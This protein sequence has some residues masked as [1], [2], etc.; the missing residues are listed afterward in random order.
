MT[1]TTNRLSKKKIIAGLCFWLL[2]AL[3]L[4]LFL[5]KYYAYHFFFIE[6]SQMFL[7]TT[8]FWND[9]VSNI[10]GFNLWLTEFLVQFFIYPYSGAAIEALLL[11]LVGSGTSC[12]I[13]RLDKNRLLFPLSLLPLISLMFMQFDFN[14]SLEGTLAF[15]FML[16]ALNGYVRI[17]RIVVRIFSGIIFSIALFLLFG[18]IALLFAICGLV[19]EIA[20]KQKRWFL[21][22]IPLLLVLMMGICS[23]FF[24][25]VDEFRW[26]FLP[27]AYYIDS[28]I[29]KNVIYYSWMA[30][31]GVII[32]SAVTGQRIKDALPM[33][34]RIVIYSLQ[35]IFV[36]LV[37]YYG[38]KEYNEGK[39]LMLKELDYYARTEQWDKTIKRCRGK[40]SNYLYKCHLNMALANQGRLADE[41]FGYD[42]AGVEGLLVKWNKT[43]NISCMLSDIYYTMGVLAPAQEMA[44]EGFVCAK[45]NSNPRMLKRLIETNLIY[46]EYAVAEKYISLLERTFAYKEWAS[47][48]RRFLYNDKT[49]L[50]DENLGA[51]RIALPDTGKLALTDGLNDELEMV[52]KENPDFKNSIEYLGA[53]YLLSKDLQSFQALIDKYY[54]TKALP[55]LPR[56]FQEAL[57]VMSEKETEMWERYNI[58][59]SIIKRFSTYKQQV[60]GNKQNPGIAN[61]LYSSFGDTYWFYFMFK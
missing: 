6:Q 22:T 18:S 17:R 39:S 58:S 45:G 34:K 33:K 53:I 35:F 44:F 48:Q 7:W 50:E 51:R 56:S 41:M 24:A 8:S 42:Q 43:E 31:V 4:F 59:E 9:T 21:G 32:L 37:F 29:P 16:A 27:D 55:T 26:A 2:V 13:G 19:Y 40:L 30:L 46:G 57:I 10:G 61:I 38:F 11:V 25:A 60:L 28:L 52:I 23:V 20:K 15:I 36:W 54:G 47:N 12:L 5:Q 49:V 1:H 14:Y 3:A